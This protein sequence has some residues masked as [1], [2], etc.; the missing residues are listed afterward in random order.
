MATFVQVSDDGRIH[1]FLTGGAE[2]AN[3]PN[4]YEVPELDPK[5][6]GGTYKEGKMIA[7]PD[8]VVQEDQLPDV[9]S[10]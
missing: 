4:T 5:F 2:L 1:T 3:V 8:P 6:L 9:K 7:P 10:H